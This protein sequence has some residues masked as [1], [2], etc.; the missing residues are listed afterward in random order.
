MWFDVI[1]AADSIDN[2]ATVWNEGKNVGT[3]K[4]HSEGPSRKGNTPDFISKCK[5]FF[6]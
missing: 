1:N 6:L 3:V 4:F 2:V 5:F